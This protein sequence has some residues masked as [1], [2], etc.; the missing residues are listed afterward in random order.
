MAIEKNN[1][2]TQP[3]ELN[4]SELE[5][6]AGGRAPDTSAPSYSLRPCCYMP[7]EP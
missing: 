2:Q 6:A 1:E 7:T 5:Q 4:D 3:V